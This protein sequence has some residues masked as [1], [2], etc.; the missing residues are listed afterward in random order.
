MATGISFEDSF[1]AMVG[2]LTNVGASIASLRNHYGILPDTTKMLLIFAMLAGRL[3]IMTLL[4][5]FLPSFWKR[6]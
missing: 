3:E 6:F 1:A 2:C 5:L 4:V